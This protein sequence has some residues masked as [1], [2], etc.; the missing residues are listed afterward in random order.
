[1]VL[2]PML[3]SNSYPARICVTGPTR[4]QGRIC[5]PGYGRL[6][7]SSL[8]PRRL[9]AQTLPDTQIT[10][11]TNAAPMYYS[12]S[13]SSKDLPVNSRC[14]KTE[15][16]V[17][18]TVLISGWLPRPF[19]DRRQCVYRTLYSQRRASAGETAMAWRAGHRQARSALKMPTSTTANAMAEKT[20]NNVEKSRWRLYCGSCSMA[21]LRINVLLK[22]PLKPALEICWSEATDAIAARMECR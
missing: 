14:S 8:R 16:I 4:R 15:K 6:A 13:G 22:P 17:Q 21:S 12:G 3:P 1:M 9:Q 11:Y 7:T 10:P 20:P 18:I 19:H 2:L 5:A